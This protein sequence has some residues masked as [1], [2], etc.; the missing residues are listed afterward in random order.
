MCGAT[1]FPAR[2]E[3]QRLVAMNVANYRILAVRNRGAFIVDASPVRRTFAAIRARAAGQPSRKGGRFPFDIPAMTTAL[4]HQR[5]P[6]LFIGV[7]GVKFP[8]RFSPRAII[9]S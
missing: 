9:A 5:R 1:A 8:L 4:V 3:G 2:H 6:I 7:N